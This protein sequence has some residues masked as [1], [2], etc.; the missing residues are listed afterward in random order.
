MLRVSPAGLIAIAVALL[1]SSAI[2]QNLE[3]TKIRIIYA[4]S[5]DRIEP[6]PLKNIT[7]TNQM[8]LSLNAGNNVSEQ[9]NAAAGKQQWG[10]KVGSTL[11]Q[12]WRVAGPNTL[13]RAD[14]FPNDT[15]TMRIVVSGKNCTLTIADT[16][17][18]GATYFVRPMLSQPGK[19]GHYS[20]MTTLDT[21]CNIE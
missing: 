13:V 5:F 14:Q 2:C 3:A 10:W 17:K 20:R 19:A 6:Q 15:R 18:N 12:G 21:H 1:P 8:T 16:L 9:W 7:V 4:D 11:G